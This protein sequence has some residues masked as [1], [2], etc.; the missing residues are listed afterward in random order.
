MITK[1]RALANVVISDKKTTHQVC[2]E[3]LDEKK[4]KFLVAVRESNPSPGIFYANPKLF[5]SSN[6]VHTF[7]RN[8]KM[9]GF[10]KFRIYGLLAFI[11]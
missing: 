11:K 2:I 4:L 5:Y 7:V 6:F 8:S 10:T 9:S 3:I 1:I